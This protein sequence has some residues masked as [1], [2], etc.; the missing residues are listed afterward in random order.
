MTR[1]LQNKQQDLFGLFVG[2]LR[3]Q[4]EK[5]GKIKIND[6]R[7]EATHP[8]AVLPW[9]RASKARDVQYVARLLVASW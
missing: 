4:M 7:D 1:L 6:G 2:N 9:D 8:C 5:S 3:T